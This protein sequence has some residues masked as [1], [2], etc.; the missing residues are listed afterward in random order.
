MF[1][2]INLHL[3]PECFNLLKIF[4][5]L[6]A[7]IGLEVSTIEWGPL[8][9]RCAYLTTLTNVTLFYSVR[10]VHTVDYVRHYAP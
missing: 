6:Y 8:L 1:I 7:D 4:M 3:A 5:G 2:K 9:L 10:K